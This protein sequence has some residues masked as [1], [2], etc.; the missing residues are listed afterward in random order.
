MILM[1]KF[2]SLTTV[3]MEIGK[4][5]FI[6]YHWK[7]LQEVKCFIKNMNLTDANYHWKNWGDWILDIWWD[8]TLQP[9]S[10][11]FSE[12]EHK[13]LIKKAI[14]ETRSVNDKC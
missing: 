1:K 4:R 2:V 8:E 3:A 12:K 9:Q 11:T 10:Y 7:I 6:N 14:V 13:R 5:H